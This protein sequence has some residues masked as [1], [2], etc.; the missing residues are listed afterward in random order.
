MWAR[1]DTA[2]EWLRDYLTVDRLRELVP[3]S[4]G[5][6]VRR[7]ELPN[8]RAVN[9]V[10]EGILG[11]GVASSVRFDP[12]AKGLGEFLRSPRGRRA[13]PRARGARVA[14]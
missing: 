5:L 2:H 6:V 9:F 11:D 4:A 10:L 13:R 14:E 8:L 7:T 1:S 12:Q 3:E